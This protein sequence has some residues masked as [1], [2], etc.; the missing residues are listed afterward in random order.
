MVLPAAT[1]ASLVSLALD[2]PGAESDDFNCG[3]PLLD[4]LRDEPGLARVEVLGGGAE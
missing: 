2:H 3:H 4:M 1:L